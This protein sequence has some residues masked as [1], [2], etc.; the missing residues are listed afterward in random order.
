LRIESG[1]RRIRED[2]EVEVEDRA[3]GHLVD[4]LRRAH[5]GE[6]AAALAYLG[7]ARSL[8]DPREAAEVLTIAC[9]EL[10][11]RRSVFRMLD[12][13]GASPGKLR[14]TLFLILG[15]GLGRL[16][17]V[18][19]WLA[20][21]FGAGWL[22]AGNIQEYEEAAGIAIAAG[23]PELAPELL[24]MAEVEWEHE[25]YFRSKVMASRVGPWLVWPVPAP[26]DSI[27]PKMPARL[28]RREGARAGPP[29]DPAP[30]RSLRR[31][32]W[33]GTAP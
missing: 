31:T 15:E 21:M 11:H 27:G 33:R 17:R 4:V 3:L 8:E 13:V 1:F 12:D 32:V 24:R 9:E 30:A 16:C 23:R 10:E 25:R 22:E 26:K 19:G 20:P 2:G 6:L 29:R 18:S 14:E 5:A 7:H 28:I